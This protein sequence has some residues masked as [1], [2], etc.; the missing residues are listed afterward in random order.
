MVFAIPFACRFR[1]LMKSISVYSFFTNA[2]SSSSK[3]SSIATVLFSPTTKIKYYLDSLER[4]I[5]PRI[6]GKVRA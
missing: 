1:Y 5:T 6:S 4:L 3:P 2:S